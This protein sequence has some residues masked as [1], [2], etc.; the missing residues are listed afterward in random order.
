MKRDLVSRLAAALEAGDVDGLVDLYAEDAVL[1]HPL[2][3]EPL[4]GRDAIRASEQELVDAFSDIE[5]EVARVLAE[6]DDLAAEVVVR[7]THRETGRKVEAPCAWLFRLG[8]DGKIVEEHDY[9]D[10]AAFYA[11][12]G[13][14]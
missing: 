13:E 2:S 3:P 9:L 7:A 4:Q 12:L 11:A 14:S 10:T 1:H 5:I 8:A 6:G